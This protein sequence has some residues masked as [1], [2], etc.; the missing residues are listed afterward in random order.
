MNKFPLIT[1]HTGCM[2]HPDHSFESLQE[3][4][5]LGAD[6]YEDD[7]RSTRDGVPVLAHDD[8]IVLSDGS[9]GSLAEMT[10]KELNSARLAPIP[11]LQ[12]VLE[13]IREAGKIM[14][15]DIK[16]DKA[17][18]PVSVLVDRMGMAEMVFLSGCEYG[19]AVKASRYAPSIRRL[20]NVNM[21]SFGSLRYNEAMF[22]ACA[23][24][25]EAGCFG[26]NVPYQVVQPEL[27]EVVQRSGLAI[28]VWTVMEADDMRRLAQLGVDSIT[29]RDPAKLIAVREETDFAKENRDW[30]IS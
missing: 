26:I 7:I 17:L 9:R 22:Q 20:L 1:A 19:S 15:L 21:Q 12:D 6:I 28:Y 30:T 27:M 2:G 8:D 3:A 24:A 23:N 5:R 14:N 18:E 25:R 13:Q 10:L 29:T 16:T 11:T 4:L